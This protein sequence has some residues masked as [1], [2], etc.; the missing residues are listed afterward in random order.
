MDW[1]DSY[2]KN[3]L[4]VSAENMIKELIMEIHLI[5]LTVHSENNLTLNELDMLYRWPL[6]VGV[7]I[8]IE[9][10]VRTLYDRDRGLETRYNGRNYEP[11]YFN[12]I[13]SA[14]IAYYND[15]SLNAQL[16]NNLTKVLSENIDLELKVINLQHTENETNKTGISKRQYTL[17]SGVRFLKRKLINVYLSLTRMYLKSPIA[18]EDSKWLNLIFPIKDRIIELP[19]KH[20]PADSK[21]R[22]KV[23]NIV[24]I[25]NVNR[26]EKSRFL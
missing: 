8:F 20:L 6:Y 9:R 14:C 26:F 17:M 22:E 10:L 24:A 23:K 11:V 3:K 16:L 15:D 19:Y 7:N 2:N 1:T 25:P 13:E 4:A 12:N 21:A 5:K 18:F